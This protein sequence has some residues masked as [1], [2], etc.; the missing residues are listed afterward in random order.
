MLLLSLSWG[1]KVVFAVFDTASFPAY[2]LSMGYH[3][4]AVLLILILTVARYIARS[5]ELT[6]GHMVNLLLT[7][8]LSALSI[9]LLLDV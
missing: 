8:N 5:Q 1:K 6:A 7:K 4:R 3:F 9:N 2:Y